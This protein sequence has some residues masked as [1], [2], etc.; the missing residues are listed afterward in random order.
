MIQTTQWKEDK[1]KYDQPSE[2]INCKINV[3]NIANRETNNTLSKTCFT[4]FSTGNTS[5]LQ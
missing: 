1:K 3:E 5:I 4:K 2:C